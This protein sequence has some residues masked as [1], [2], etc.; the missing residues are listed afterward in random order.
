MK[1]LTCELGI[2]KI[3]VASTIG[4]GIYRAKNWRVGKG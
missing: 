3:A 4:F 1:I 2:G